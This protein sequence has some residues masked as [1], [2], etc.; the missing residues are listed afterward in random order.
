[1]LTPLLTEKDPA[2]SSEGSIDPLGMYA[3]ADSLAVRLVPGVRERQSHPRFLTAIA[4]SLAVCSEFDDDQVASDGVSEPWQVFEWHVV[5]GLVRSLTDEGQL[6]GLPG[7]EKAARAIQDK[8]PLSA[9]RYLKTP[10]VFGFHGVYRILSRTLDIEAAGLLGETGYE[11]LDTWANEQGLPGF[12]GTMNGS[13][14]EWRQRLVSAVGDGLEKGTVARSGGWSGWEFFKNHLAHH[15]IGRKERK[16]IVNSLVRADGGFRGEVLRFLTSDKGRDAWQENSS[17]RRF[18]EALAS[19]CEPSL[20][21]LLRAIDIYERF[22]RLLEDAFFDCLFQMSRVRNYVYAAEL[23]SLPGVQEAAE[24]VPRLSIELVERL[25]PFGES[26]R[27]QETFSE[28]TQQMPAKQWVECLLEHHRKVQSNKPPNGKAPWYERFDD[29]SYIIRTGYVR[30]SGGRH[31]E[32]YVHGYRTG[33]LW[34]F[35]T[36]LKLVS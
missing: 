25:A 13:G 4:T 18:H 33:P 23:G 20:K 17:E 8:V 6:Q 27:F 9:T 24:R 16:V 10:S 31:D 32:E 5:E 1:M 12:C 22:A 14:A 26:I 15:N 34:S 19:I 28:I 2:I 30:G 36:D 7:R 29:G 11:L 35:A 21:E 3:I